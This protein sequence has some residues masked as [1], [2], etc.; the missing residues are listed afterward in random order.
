M[1]EKLQNIVNLY[2][3]VLPANKYVTCW[4]FAELI[5]ENFSLTNP[6]TRRA[7]G[8]IESHIDLYYKRIRNYYKVTKI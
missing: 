8:F 3:Y 4:R 2:G 6:V 1:S 7:V 5:Q